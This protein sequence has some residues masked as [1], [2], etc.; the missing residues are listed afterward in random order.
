MVVIY[1][2]RCPT[3]GAIRYIGKTKNGR[4]RL[5]AHINDARKRTY[6]HHASNWIL[7]LLRTGLEPVFEV[8]KELEP[9]DDW[10]YWE[11]RF[12]AEARARGEKLTNSTSG[13][14]GAPELTED[15]RE[16]K[17]EDSRQMW[18]RPGYRERIVAHR[19][20][21]DFTQQQADRLTGRWKD[22]AHRDKMQ[23]ARWTDEQR[24]DQV[25]RLADRQA[26]IKKSLTP[27]VIARRNAS[28]KAA[29]DR[30]KASAA[31]QVPKSV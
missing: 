15:A 29:W 27:E 20:S 18:K 2:L 3:S 25:R 31:S 4:G 10:I 7:S 23:A 24:A 26:K 30:R 17:A 5:R 6:K 1:A 22:P 9:S 8:L 19:N 14:D 28:I 11:R 13:G 21:P 12:I 16:R